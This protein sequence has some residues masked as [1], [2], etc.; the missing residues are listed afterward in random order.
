M[1]GPE[2]GPIILWTEPGE[3][4]E[5]GL[6]PRLGPGDKPAAGDGP[7][8]DMLLD[9]SPGFDICWNIERDNG[10]LIRLDITDFHQYLKLSKGELFLGP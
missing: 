1:P 7:E 2:L 3:G 4:S 8:R 9:R 5:P 10:S 6:G